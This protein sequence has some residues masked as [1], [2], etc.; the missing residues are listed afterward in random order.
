MKRKAENCD[1]GFTTASSGDLGKATLPLPTCSRGKPPGY[2][3]ADS[4]PCD[5]VMVSQVAGG[6]L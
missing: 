1:F 6:I 4:L 5:F 2:K 3:F